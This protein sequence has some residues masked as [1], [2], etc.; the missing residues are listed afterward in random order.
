MTTFN[1]G[2][3]ADIL[4]ISPSGK[5]FFGVFLSVWSIHKVFE[6]AHFDLLSVFNIQYPCAP[7][8]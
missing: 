3:K 1:K 5:K 7:I 4:S 2:H 6:M 8:Q